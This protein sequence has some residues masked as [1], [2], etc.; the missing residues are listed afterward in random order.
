MLLPPVSL[1]RAL[2]VLAGLT[3]GLGAGPAL[4]D[5]FSCGTRVVTTG[6]PGGAVR[7]ACGE[8]TEIRQDTILR[9]P[10]VWRHGRP[11]IVGDG[12]V[13]VSVE[14]WLYNFGSSRLMQRVT[15]KDGTVTDID[16][17]GYGFNQ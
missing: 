12:Y 10:T 7:A 3:A 8:P 4:A 11:V 1:P 2:L 14:I 13:E 16:T 15:V 6:M 17:L 9:R 5:G